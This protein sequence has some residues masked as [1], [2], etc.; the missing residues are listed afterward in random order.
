MVHRYHYCLR[1]HRELGDVM[2]TNTETTIQPNIS[3]RLIPQC[4][5]MCSLI[6]MYPGSAHLHN[7][8]LT[9][10]VEELQHLFCPY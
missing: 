6:P 7:T 8:T 9:V 10:S 4:S 2:L 5:V 3:Q 1:P